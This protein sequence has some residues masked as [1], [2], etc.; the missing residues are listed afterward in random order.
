MAS[1][2]KGTRVF[3]ATAFGSAKTTTIATNAAECVLTS[4]A[5]GLAN[6]DIVEVTSGWGGLNKRVARLKSITTDTMTL[7]NIDTS[8]TSLYPAGSGIGSVRK[9]TTFQQ[10]TGVLDI[11]NSGGDAKQVEYD[12][13]EDDTS[14]S[15]ND[16]FA[17]SSYTLDLDADKDDTA[18]YLALRSL[19]EVRSDTCAYFLKKNGR[20]MYLPCTV[21]LNENETFRRGAINAVKCSLNGNN[22][23]TKYAS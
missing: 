18:G 21:A 12:Y 1:L 6:G 13:M 23:V 5:H 4:A 7:E 16:G 9:I 20:K 3:V 19:T 15:I 10:V 8:S 17:A 11:G 14:Y 22:R 2:P